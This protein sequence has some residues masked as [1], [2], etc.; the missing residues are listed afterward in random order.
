MLLDM[1]QKKN[2]KPSSPFTPSPHTAHHTAVICNHEHTRTRP[3]ECAGV[4]RARRDA[5]VR[6]GCGR[7]VHRLLGQD[8]GWRI[9]RVRREEP[10]VNGLQRGQPDERASLKGRQAG[11]FFPAPGLESR[12]GQRARV[13]DREV[14]QGVSGLAG[15]Q[16]RKREDPRRGEGRG[17]DE[18]PR[19]RPKHCPM[20]PRRLPH[21]S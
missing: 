17:Q 19:R 8:T 15:R 2:V 3:A 10:G 6:G 4:S 18:P 21:Q 16:W 12:G 9:G 1:Y 11:G 14:G 7:V 13:P 5:S 20:R